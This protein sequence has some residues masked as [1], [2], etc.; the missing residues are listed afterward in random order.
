[1]ARTVAGL[2]EGTRITDHISLGVLARTF[3]LEKVQAALIKTG[4]QSKRQRNL[5]AHVVVYYSI[6]LALYMQV[7]CKEVLRCLLEGVRWLQGPE[8]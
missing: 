5:P 6:A 8:G 2:P 1:M 4:R 7:C 3:P